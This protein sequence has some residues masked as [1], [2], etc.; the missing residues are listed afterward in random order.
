MNNVKQFR[1]QI[2]EQLRGCFHWLCAWEQP[3]EVRQGGSGWNCG[4]K[5][6]PTGT[7]LK[8]HP[9]CRMKRYYRM[10]V[11]SCLLPKWCWATVCIPYFSVFLC[12]GAVLGFLDLLIR[13]WSIFCDFCFS[14]LLKAASE[15]LKLIAQL[16]FRVFFGF[17]EVTLFSVQFLNH[18]L[19]PYCNGLHLVT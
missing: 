6:D 7:G 4:T 2:F 11:A 5:P 12:V 13:F 14:F 10:L 18:W 19:L 15:V 16:I 1:R 17:M 3:Q 9:C 8:I